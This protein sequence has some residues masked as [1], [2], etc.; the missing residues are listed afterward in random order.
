[1]YRL[2]A[3]ALVRHLRLSC[4]SNAD[5]VV[6]CTPLR[7]PPQPPDRYL[8]ASMSVCH[9]YRHRRGHHPQVQCHLEP[10]WT[11]ARTFEHPERPPGSRSLSR[12]ST[13]ASPRIQTH[14]SPHFWLSTTPARRVYSLSRTRSR[15]MGNS[16]PGQGHAWQKESSRGISVPS[17]GS[18]DSNCTS[19]QD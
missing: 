2:S 6:T 10:L 3:D 13:H 4:L 1:M 17:F 7:I 15:C 11:I 14:R 16:G 9:C 19:V 18:W 5:A 12:R 8:T